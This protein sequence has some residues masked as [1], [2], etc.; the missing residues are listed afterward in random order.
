MRIHCREA[1]GCLAEHRRREI[2]AGGKNPGR[3]YKVVALL[4]FRENEWDVV[5]LVAPGVHVHGSEEEAEGAMEDQPARWHG[6][7]NSETRSEVVPVRILQSIGI[8]VLASD[9]HR[10]YTIVENQVRVGIRDVD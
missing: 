9:E 6:L 10:G 4:G 5:A 7:G 3:R 8:A 1:D 2:E